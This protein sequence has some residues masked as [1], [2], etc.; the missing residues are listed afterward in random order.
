MADFVMDRG[1]DQLL[2]QINQAA[3]GRSKASDGGVGDLE[4][5]LRVSDHNPESPPPP[6]N[7]DDQVDARDFTHDPAHGADMRVVSEAIR[8][9]RDARVRYV[10]FNGRIFSSYATSD[11]KAWEWGTYAGSNDHAGHMHVSVNDVHHDETQRW[12][13]GIDM[14]ESAGAIAEQ[15]RI[16]ALMTLKPEHANSTRIVPEGRLATVPLIDLLNRVDKHVMAMAEG[17]GEP[18]E[19]VLSTDQLGQLADMIVA[20]LG[21]LQF[22]GRPT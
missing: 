1:L 5:A 4:H 14:A 10:I 17:S 9:S 22:V 3:P 13:I 20:R 12:E 7:P 8:L 21:A 11:R 2:V 18:L 19:V 15:Y 6:G 16:L